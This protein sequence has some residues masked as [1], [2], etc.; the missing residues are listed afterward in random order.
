MTCSG[1]WGRGSPQNDTR[2]AA[3]RIISRERETMSHRRRG[4][5]ERDAG[6]GQDQNRNDGPNLKMIAPKK[7]PVIPSRNSPF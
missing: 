3:G 2:D 4:R 5:R 6:N 7:P 1:H